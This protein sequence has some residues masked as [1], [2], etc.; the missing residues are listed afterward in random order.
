MSRVKALVLSSG[1]VDSTTCLALAIE[2]VGKDNITTVSISY[3]QKHSIELDKAK[4]IAEYYKVNHQVI[5]LTN[6]GIMD[7]S[8]CSLLTSSGVDIEHGDYASQIDKQT[9]GIVNTYVPFRNG[10]ILSSAAALALSLYPDDEID[11][12]LGAHADD[13][14][15][16]AYADCTPEFTKT[17]GQAINLG[18]YGKVNIKTPLI[19]LNK[20]GV[21]RE[22]LKL[23]TPYH[24]TWS[25]YE[26]Q[27]KPCGIC[28]TCIDRE[29]AFKLNG[30][31][32]P[33]L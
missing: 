11:I 19:N 30:I 26:G 4:E 28:G 32:D 24:L 14:A 15:G 29:I 5:D 16:A 7:N 21:I 20:A 10:L 8:K 9:S 22:G 18:T 3:G 31:E 12:Y 33:A 27:G 17:I 25:C 23:N 6:T 1:G 2:E 13:N